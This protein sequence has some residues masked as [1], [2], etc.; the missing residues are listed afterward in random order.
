MRS[1][2]SAPNRTEAMAPSPVHAPRSESQ[3]QSMAERREK[4]LTRRI[5]SSME[6]EVLVIVRQ[7]QF[8]ARVRRKV[9]VSFRELLVVDPHLERVYDDSDF[10][11]GRDRRKVLRRQQDVVF[12]VLLR[13]WHSFISCTAPGDQAPQTYGSALPLEVAV[14]KL[15]LHRF[16][17]DQ[18]N[19]SR[20]SFLLP[21]RENLV[22]QVVCRCAAARKDLLQRDID[23]ES[24]ELFLISLA[25]RRGV[26]RDERDVLP[27]GAKERDRLDDVFGSLRRRDRVSKEPFH[28]ARNSSQD[29][30]SS[31]SPDDSITLQHVRSASLAAFE[32]RDYFSHQRGTS[33]NARRGGR[34]A[35]ATTPRSR[36]QGRVLRVHW[37][38]ASI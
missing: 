20:L 11:I 9:V 13:E 26:I 19:P 8:A 3:D 25:G 34:L 22:S 24:A 16:L 5:P 36:R 29:V 32:S 28:F 4:E 31:S 1:F 30:A 17:S 23:S 7:D 27:S 35:R 10:G 12:G 6:Q 14:S 15:L 33:S 21:S 37:R 38:E 18:V 2:G